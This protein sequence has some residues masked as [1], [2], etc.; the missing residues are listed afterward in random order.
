MFFPFLK[1]KEVLKNK[2]HCV[3]FSCGKH[4]DH[5]LIS[6]KTLQRLHLQGIGSMYLYID[7]EDSLTN[8][9]INLLKK[10][11]FNLII[12]KAKKVTGAGEQAITTELESF[13]E[14]GKEINS[15]DYI[16]KIDSDILFVSGDIF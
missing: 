12:K 16:A 7:K 4:F 1:R 15:E 8:T 11:K 2:I 14:I 9:Q 13:L 10:L 3:Y 6:L 5:L